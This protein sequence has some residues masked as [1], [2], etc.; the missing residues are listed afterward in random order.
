MS[1]GT[2]RLDLIRGHLEVHG[3]DLVNSLTREEMVE[4]LFGVCLIFTA[5]S[6]VPAIQ[7]VKLHRKSLLVQYVGDINFGIRTSTLHTLPLPRSNRVWSSI[8]IS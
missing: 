3:G 8:R 2:N 1:W 5:G 6:G 7:A 4:D